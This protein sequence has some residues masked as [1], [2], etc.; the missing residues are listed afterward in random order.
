MPI[1]LEEDLSAGLPVSAGAAGVEVAAPATLD[2]AVGGIVQY[3]SVHIHVVNSRKRDERIWESRESR[4]NWRPSGC[5]AVK[6]IAARYRVTRREWSSEYCVYA[7]IKSMNE[8][9]G[10]L[11]AVSIE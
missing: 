4:S 10:G 6:S 3:H 8:D 2:D 11:E 7:R 9:V 5:V 1:P